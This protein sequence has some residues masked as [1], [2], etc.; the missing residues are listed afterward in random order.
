MRG[1]M[2]FL[3][4]L[5]LVACTATP[6]YV[7][8]DTRQ[9][10]RADVAIDLEACRTYAAR[11]YRP[12][13]PTG[14]PYLLDM[15]GLSDEAPDATDG[16]WRPDREP[17]PTTNVNAL[18]LHD[19]PVDY[20]GYPGYLDYSPGYLDAILEKCMHDRGWVYAAGTGQPQETEKPA[21]E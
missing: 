5:Q 20:T 21:P 7:W 9:P 4:T 18:P 3:T 11:Q 17:F 13:M 14:T 8:Q 12:G 1:L 6:P 15:K 2:L 19:V 16:T 10:P